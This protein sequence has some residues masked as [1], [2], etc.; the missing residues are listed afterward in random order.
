ML[1]HAVSTELSMLVWIDWRDET[2]LAN[3]LAFA[4][5]SQ[6][7]FAIDVRLFVELH[8][9]AKIGIAKRDAT[10]APVFQAFRALILTMR[11]SLR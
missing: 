11:S 1:V 4:S 2:A 10:T 7:L 8:P 5:P 6:L 9:F 3:A